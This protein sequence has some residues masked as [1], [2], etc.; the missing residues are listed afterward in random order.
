[1]KP[2][3]FTLPADPIDGHE[4]HW[5]AVESY[6]YGNEPRVVECR[7]VY[8]VLAP[9]AQGALPFKNEWKI[10]RGGEFS[11]RT[12]CGWTGAWENRD[13]SV[14]FATE[15]EALAEAVKICRE[16]EQ[17]A[18]ME[19]ARLRRVRSLLETRLSLARVRDNIGRLR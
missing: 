10:F 17:R 6:S 2:P 13:W 7:A 19:T 14:E 11:G 3:P 15:A 12:S 9:A 8:H 1:M 5:W 4:V 16:R 18:K